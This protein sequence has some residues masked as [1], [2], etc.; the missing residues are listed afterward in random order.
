M[1]CTGR[2]GILLR[3]FFQLEGL[4][5]RKCSHVLNPKSS[6]VG[7]YP[8]AAAEL[9]RTTPDGGPSSVLSPT[10]SGTTAAGRGGRS[11]LWAW[12]GT[13]EAA[14]ASGP[15]LDD[16]AARQ[17]SLIDLEELYVWLQ[18]FEDPALARHETNNSYP[19]A[20]V[21]L[22]LLAF[23]SGQ[24]CEGK[25]FASRLN[26]NPFRKPAQL[27][28]SLANRELSFSTSATFTHGACRHTIVHPT[29]GTSSHTGNRIMK[30]ADRI[31][32]ERMTTV[33]EKR[34][35][36]QSAPLVPNFNR[37]LLGEVADRG[38]ELFPLIG[39]V[40]SFVGP[41]RFLPIAIFSGDVLIV[42]HSS[43]MDYDDPKLVRTNELKPRDDRPRG[44]RFSN[45]EGKEAVER[46]L[47]TAVVTL[48]FLPLLKWHGKSKLVPGGWSQAV[49]IR[50]ELTVPDMVQYS[51]DIL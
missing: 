24:R 46:W 32:D 38:C 42:V 29:C 28:L 13:S 1:S 19:G 18:Q 47:L 22:E 8:R 27:L 3:Q 37:A 43:D 5:S 6:L 12:G 14:S 41:D 21:R 30:T 25:R 2:G 34:Y 35:L 45:D 15:P 44:K 49:E 51:V 36:Q 11:S 4:P 26:V 39:L 48:E 31:P 16:T 17:Q 33:S 9:D 20:L 7:S 50:L 10:C 23:R 40:G